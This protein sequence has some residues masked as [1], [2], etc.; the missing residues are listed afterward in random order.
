MDSQLTYLLPYLLEVTL[1]VLVLV[2]VLAG[3]LAFTGGIGSFDS[4]YRWHHAN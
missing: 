3:L 2:L 4:G 1:L